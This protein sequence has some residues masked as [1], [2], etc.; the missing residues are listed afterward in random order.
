MLDIYDDSFWSVEYFWES[1]VFSWEVCSCELTLALL[2][3]KS[4]FA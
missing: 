4:W 1:E 3:S 2:S